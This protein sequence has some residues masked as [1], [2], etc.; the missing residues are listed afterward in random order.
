MKLI[1]TGPPNLHPDMDDVMSLYLVERNLRFDSVST[2]VSGGDAGVD[3]A[4]ESW[5]RV[6]RI[7]VVKFRANLLLW[8]Q[9]AIPRRNREM[10]L[11]ADAALVVTWARRTPG[12]KEMIRNMMYLRKILSVVEVSADGQLKHSV[13]I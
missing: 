4:A 6:N 1:I 9:S 8:G 7:K 2:I 10:A 3:A 12:S 13:Y 11:Y 5:A